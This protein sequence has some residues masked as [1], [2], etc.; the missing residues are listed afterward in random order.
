MTRPWTKLLLT[1]SLVFNVLFA[2]GYMRSHATM[3]G[4][5]Q[6]FE[7][8]ARWFA[9][10]L[11]LDDQQQAQFDTLLAETIKKRGEIHKE[12]LPHLERMLNELVKDEPDKQVLQ[13][14]ASSDRHKKHREFK[15]QQMSKLMAILRPDQRRKFVELIKTRMEKRSGH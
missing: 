9:K 1:I 2:A 13:E 5:H 15:V 12:K 6:R 11:D 3:P 10:Q 8:R 4:R 7:H 14:F